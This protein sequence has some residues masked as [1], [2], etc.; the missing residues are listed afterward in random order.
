MATRAAL[1]RRIV[2]LA[3][4]D[5]TREASAAL[6]ATLASLGERLPDEDVDVIAGALPDGLVPILRNRKR[7]GA[8]DV[9]EFFDRVR[10][11]EGV[12]LGFAREHAQVVCR[13]LGE[14]WR[15]DVLGVLDRALPESF[16]ELF[17][18][19]PSSA[20][21]PP[22]DHRIPHV[23]R[24][25]TLATGGPGAR[26]SLADSRPPGAQAHS[27]AREAKPHADSK[28]SSAQGMT[29]E[30]LDDSLATAHPDARRTLSKASD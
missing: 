5:T 20:S 15:E 16:A 23:A 27:I 13:A 19:P 30:R 14:T 11:R 26:H 10:R 2:H 7:K 17:R 22:P 24:G 9:A 12:S 28:L 4:L 6:R 8:F 3:G 25:H 21:A 29:Q 18:P 1:L